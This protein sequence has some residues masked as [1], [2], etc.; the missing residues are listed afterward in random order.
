M[1]PS[2]AAQYI[3]LMAE[4]AEAKDALKSVAE[5]RKALEATF[6]EYLSSNGLAHIS[7]GGYIIEASQK[8]SKKKPKE[9]EIY[10]ELADPLGTTPDQLKKLFDDVKANKTVITS[11]PSIAKP[12][13]LPDSVSAPKTPHMS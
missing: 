9:T 7:I 3:E 12:R 13:R 11:K 10:T 8:K 4:E 5:R 2:S 6:I 1:D